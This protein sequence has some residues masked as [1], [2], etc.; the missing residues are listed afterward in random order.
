MTEDIHN[1]ETNMRAEIKL[2]SDS[3]K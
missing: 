2:V 3:L 1:T